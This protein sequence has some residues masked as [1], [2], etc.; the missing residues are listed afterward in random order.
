MIISRIRLKGAFIEV[1]LAGRTPL[2]FNKSLV[3]RIWAD[4][5]AGDDEIVNDT[6]R[7]STLLG[8]S[9]N[10]T[11]FGDAGAD[12]LDGSTGDDRLDGGLGANTIV[13]GGG[14][15]IV[16]HS[17]E[18]AG[19]FDVTNSPF[20]AD[21][22]VTFNGDKAVDTVIP[23]PELTIRFTSGDDTIDGILATDLTI[24]A[25]DGTDH[26][27]V[28]VDQSDHAA[29]ETLLGGQGNDAFNINEGFVA[30]LNSGGDGNDYFND[31]G[32]RN[33]SA[34]STAGPALT[35]MIFQC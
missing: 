13:G 27:N 12:S 6:S 11:I 9:G 1:S 17:R 18:T 14:R 3:K 10:D 22:S 33:T 5:Y 20:D 19:N 26:I 34:R 16:D 28:L 4:A 15:D 35:L 31:N 30:D 25:G 23:Q 24:D 8:S 29:H 7:P 32:V 21:I 2:S